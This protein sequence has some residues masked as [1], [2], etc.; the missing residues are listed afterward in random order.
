MFGKQVPAKDT[1]VESSSTLAKETTPVVKKNDEDIATDKVEVKVEV[2]NI[3]VKMEEE[4]Q[5]RG[6]AKQ[7]KAFVPDPIQIKGHPSALSHINPL[8][9]L[10]PDKLQGT[11]RDCRHIIEAYQRGEDMSELLLPSHPEICSGVTENGLSYV[12]LPAKAPAGRF[13]AHLQIYSG[14]SDELEPQQ[15]IAHLTEHVAY[16]G[17][18]KRE[19][20]FG[21]GSQTNAYTDFHHTVFYACCPCVMPGSNTKMLPLALDALSDVMEAEATK[22][23]IEK[24]RSAVLSEMT[25]V[26]TIEYRVECQILGTLHA[27]NR[28][29]SRFPIGKEHLIK[30]WQRDD[31][32]RWHRTH[33]RPDNAL[34]YIVGDVDPKDAVK[35]IKKRFKHIT[36]DKQ[37]KVLSNEHKLEARYL[38]EH[39]LDEKTVKAEQSW[40][41][42]AAI[43]SFES[44]NLSGSNPQDADDNDMYDL[45]LQKT[46][47]TDGIEYTLITEKGG[48]VRSKIFKHNLLQQFS[49]HL[50][51]KRP[52]VGLRTLGDFRYNLAKRVALAALQIR[53]NVSGR[54]T[55]DVNFVEFNSLDSAREGCN[56]C[57]LDLTCASE[58]WES[59]IVSTVSAI[60]KLGKYGVTYSELERYSSALMTDAQQLYSMESM[61]EG[62]VGLSSNEL[63]NGLMETMSNNHQFM[64]AEESLVCTEAALTS[65]T[66]DEVRKAAADLA[67]HVLNMADPSMD[68]LKNELVTVIACT[69]EGHEVTHESLIKTIR[70][71]CKAPIVPEEELTVPKSLIPGDVLEKYITSFSEKEGMSPQFLSPTFTDGSDSASMANLGKLLSRRLSN[72][73]KMSILGDSPVETQ[74]G[75]LRVYLPGGRH[76]EKLLNLQPGSMSVGSRTMQEGGSFNEWS[77]EQ[78]ELFCVDHLIQ[79]EIQC[80]EDSLIMDFGFPTTVVTGEDG[81]KGTEAVLQVV[82]EVLVN[83]N[84]ESDA[85]QRAKASYKAAYDSQRKSLEQATSASLV[86]R[87]TG[88]DDRFDAID[89]VTVD[90]VTLSQAESAIMSQL[91]PANIEISMA[92]DFNTT[93]TLPMILDYLGTIQSD[94][95]KEYAIEFKGTDDATI[96]I[97][98]DKSHLDFELTDLDPRAVSYV[99]GSAPNKWGYLPVTDGN[100]KVSVTHV[101]KVLKSV[102]KNANQNDLSRRSHPFFAN[103]SL[104]LINEILNRRLF[105]NVR[106]RKQLTYDANF[107]LSGFEALRGGWYLVTVTASKEKAQAA[108]EACKDTIKALLT[109][110]KINSDNVAGAKRVVTNRHEGE[111]RSNKYWCELLGGSQSDAIPMKGPISLRDFQAV[112]ESITVRD[113][114]LILENTFGVNEKDLFT[115][116]GQTTVPDGV[117]LP[118]SDIVKSE[119]I[120]GMT[121][122]GALMN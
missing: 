118:E 1:R 12:I 98:D 62:Q 37:A 70:K 23:R 3:D 31:V 92:G 102:D 18:R 87:V 51:A 79:V 4:P 19:R 82:R 69:P 91:Q 26:N 113:L 75:H 2:A 33:Y 20:L 43:H 25:M 39:I 52:I 61:G 77:R 28:L 74:R 54:G 73:I 68:G 11:P 105:S 81:L 53:L 99:A 8:N 45:Q 90:E 88:G 89:H 10:H 7:K 119:N 80:L 50:F 97:S 9:L 71:A 14:S 32:L 34:L 95:N 101:S 83:Y 117:T 116:I 100:G 111:L 110:D 120:I 44:E 46:V 96:P 115:A 63:L 16:M 30:S 60:H 58:D 47:P 35:V 56:V 29:A 114:Q 57:S 64:S 36:A 112:V 67:N 27:E 76:A 41:F 5:L 107:S 85:M 106:E 13:E 72:G 40:H 66:V 93:E 49:L 55:G 103:A 86:E 108:L 48:T 104:L 121:R 6:T 15:G 42:P 24:E 94:A 65:L 17:S 59:A 122:G 38:M 21:T 22:S 78:V 109:S 84:W